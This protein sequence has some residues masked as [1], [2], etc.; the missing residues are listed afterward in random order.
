MQWRRAIPWWR[1]S[2]AAPSITMAAAMA[3]WRRTERRRKRCCGKPTGAPASRPP[4]CSTWKRTARARAW[5]TPLKCG[6]WEKCVLGSVKTNIGHSEPAAGVAGVIAA[7]LA[8]RHGVLPPT[9]HFARP[10]PLIPFGELPFEVRRQAG[11]WPQEQAR[12]I[13]G[14]SG[15]GFG[16]SNAHMV[17]E[18][19]PG[20]LPEPPR[21]EPPLVLPVSARSPEALRTLAGLYRDRKSTR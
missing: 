17:L 19:A 16:G 6:R 10:N 4:R 20:D 7:S 2:A 18:A 13:A 9:V 11:P 12:R 8:I 5:A 3:S 1:L 21:I 15:F 14:V